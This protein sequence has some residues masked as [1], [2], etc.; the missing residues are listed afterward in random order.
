MCLPKCGHIGATW[1]IQLNLCFL[2]PTQVHNPNGKSIAPAVL[3]Q[4]TAESPYTYNG[5]FPQNCPLPWEMWTHLIRGS[6]G[7][8]ESSTQTASRSVQP[9]LQG[10]L[11]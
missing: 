1:R 4:L 5:I 10:S 11:V 9:F 8:T 7:L 3:T 2:R 6:L